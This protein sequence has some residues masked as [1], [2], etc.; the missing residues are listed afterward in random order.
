MGPLLIQG[1]PTFSV[2]PRA[3]SERQE[4][5]RGLFNRLAPCVDE[6][7]ARNTAF[8]EADTAYLRFLIP[9]G[10][11]VLE[12]GCGLG[13]TLSRASNR[14]TAWGSTLRRR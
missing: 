4:K 2:P 7:A 14:R 6:W 9:R 13:D 1:R 12:I 3:L 8:H 5:M 10:Q 11:R